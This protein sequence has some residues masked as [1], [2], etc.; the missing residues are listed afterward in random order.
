M[1]HREENVGIL[2]SHLYSL[3]N[4]SHIEPEMLDFE[5]TGRLLN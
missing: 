3:E 4:K 2:G 5:H 1:A